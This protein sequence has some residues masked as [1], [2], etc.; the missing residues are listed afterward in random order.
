MFQKTS[1]LGTTALSSP[2][3]TTYDDVRGEDVM[4][5][6]RV[7]ADVRAEFEDRGI[8]I[9]DD[10]ELMRKFYDDQTFSKLNAT[11]GP[12]F[13]LQ[14]AEAATPEARAR[15]ARL[16]D[17]HGKLPFFMQSGGVGAATALPSYLKALALDPINAVGGFIGA[18]GKGVAKAAQ[19][20][21]MNGRNP[22]LA[23]AKAAALRGAAYEGALG[24]GFGG[25]YSVGQQNV[26]MKLGLQDSFSFG[27][28][29]ADIAGEAV[30]SGAL[31]AGIGGAFGAIR[32]G[33]ANLDDVSSYQK[34][35]L[36][37]ADEARANGDLE[38]EDQF[39]YLYGLSVE[40]NSL[41]TGAGGTAP[42]LRLADDASPEA[43][44]GTAPAAAPKP[45]RPPP[46]LSPRTLS[47]P[48]S[49]QR[50][51]KS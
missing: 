43:D 25:V 41:D 20:A 51:R 31:G 49:R 50:T 28:L 5:D 27:R 19:V 3:Q 7:I 45:T 4:T 11:I 42:E 38:E 9:E 33:G 26:D 8:Y 44:P 12:F 40:E 34:E 13:A 48:A 35:L 37:G 1:L 29:G 23:A 15:Q 10:D 6:P 18:G 17:A 21:R 16:R 24:A 32:K 39:R 36:D 30:F 14:R 22:A 2:Q 47:V 46:Q